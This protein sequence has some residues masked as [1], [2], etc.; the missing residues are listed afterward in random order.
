MARCVHAVVLVRADRVRDDFLVPV[1]GGARILG[2]GRCATCERCQ[3]SGEDGSG[4]D[5]RG[6]SGEQGCVHQGIQ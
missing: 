4:H 5:V 6:D 1:G 2:R 3:P